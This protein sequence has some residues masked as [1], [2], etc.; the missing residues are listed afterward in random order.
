MPRA[1]S[2]CYG[3]NYKVGEVPLIGRI[4]HPH[5]VNSKLIP[6]NWEYLRVWYLNDNFFQPP[7]LSMSNNSYAAI[8]VIRTFNESHMN[9]TS[10]WFLLSDSMNNYISKGRSKIVKI[11]DRNFNILTLVLYLFLHPHF[12]ACSQAPS[13]PRMHYM[14]IHPGCVECRHWPTCCHLLARVRTSKQQGKK[15]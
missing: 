13:T 8:G 14:Q 7:Q 11:T 2:G 1:G 15:W 6:L 10:R 4:T 3:L 9:P 12:G 5:V